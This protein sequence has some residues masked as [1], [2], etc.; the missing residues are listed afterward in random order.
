MSKTLVRVVAV[1]C[2]RHGPKSGLFVQG[3]QYDIPFVISQQ[4]IERTQPRCFECKAVGVRRN[5]TVVMEQVGV[6]GVD[7]N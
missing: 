1:T 5:C 6:A 4:T 7:A 2:P 3:Q